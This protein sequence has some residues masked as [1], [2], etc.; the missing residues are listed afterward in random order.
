MRRLALL[1]RGSC[2]HS[3][4]R[5]KTVAQTAATWNTAGVS[6]RGPSDAQR[7]DRHQEGTASAQPTA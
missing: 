7:S 6:L 4:D 2:K 3:T 5:V 1:R